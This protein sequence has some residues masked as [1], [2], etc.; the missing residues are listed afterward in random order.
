MTAPT[1]PVTEVFVALGSNLGDGHAH[2]D[3]AIE[4]LRGVCAEGTELRESSRILTQAVVPEERADE[5]QPDYLNAV[6]QLHTCL[7]PLELL[8]VLQDIER[9]RGRQR[10]GVPR[11]SARPLDLD[12]LLYGDLCLES[13]RLTVPHPLMTE[14]AFVLQPLAELAPHRVL[15]HTGRRVVDTLEALP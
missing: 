6:V 8:D 13:P 1:L 5:R 15:P 2:C 14:R 4:A 9:Q 12:L 3:A 11:W 7:E 10:E